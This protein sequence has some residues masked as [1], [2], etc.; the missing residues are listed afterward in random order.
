MLQRVS[1][2]QTAIAA[3]LM[4]GKVQYLMPEGE[5]WSIIDNL[6]KILEPFQNI[7]EVTSIE[8]FPT[9]SSVRPLLYKLL[10]KS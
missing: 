6:I 8:K 4:E 10:E 1:E 9:I 7:T 2:Q 5:E 3:V